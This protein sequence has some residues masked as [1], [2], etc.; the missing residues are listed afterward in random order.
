MPASPLACQPAPAPACH[1]GLTWE[2]GRQRRRTVRQPAPQPALR[3][4][5][6]VPVGTK[7]LTA[8]F[9]LINKSPEMEMASFKPF[10]AVS[11]QTSYSAQTFC[12]CPGDSAVSQDPSFDGLLEATE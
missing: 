2:V 9:W 8:I 5:A 3:H 11:D 1:W 10:K 6:P 7:G 4:Y 12:P